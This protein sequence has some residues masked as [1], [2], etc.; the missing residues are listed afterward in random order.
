VIIFDAAE[1]K[2]DRYLATN[3]V[4]AVQ[5][6]AT[7]CKLNESQGQKFLPNQSCCFW[8][9]IDLPTTISLNVISPMTVCLKVHSR[10]S[11]G[12]T[13]MFGGLIGSR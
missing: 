3:I 12:E 10:A 1:S 11:E 6:V 9:N 7:F 13:I 2:V 5:L 8:E 4:G